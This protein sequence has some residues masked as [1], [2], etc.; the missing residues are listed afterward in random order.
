VA[1]ALGALKLKFLRGKISETH[2]QKCVRNLIRIIGNTFQIDELDVLLPFVGNE[3]ERLATKYKLDFI[4]C[5][6]IATLKHG[7]YR[8]FEGPSKSILITADR[9]LAKA[10][11]S[12]GARVWE[13]TTEPS[14]S[15]N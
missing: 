6:Q 2:Y 5:L 4:D 13:C 7:K 1:E 12:E 14:P 3:F 10:A 15:L 11:R 8:I 9:E